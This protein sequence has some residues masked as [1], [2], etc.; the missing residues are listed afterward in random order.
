MLYSLHAVFLAQ[1]FLSHDRLTWLFWLLFVL[2]ADIANVCNEAALIAARHLSQH[3]NTKHFE[4]AVDRVIGG[5]L[6]WT[7]LIVNLLDIGYKPSSSQ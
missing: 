3:V 7:I 4:Q 1:F 6:T 2:G 5:K